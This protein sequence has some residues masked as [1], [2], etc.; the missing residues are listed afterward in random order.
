MIVFTPQAYLQAGTPAGGVNRLLLATLGNKIYRNE[1][2]RTEC[3]SCD[4]KRCERGCSDSGLSRCL[5]KAGDLVMTI[6]V[7]ESP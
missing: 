3:L 6:D 5:M 2:N 4:Q 7:E 1:L